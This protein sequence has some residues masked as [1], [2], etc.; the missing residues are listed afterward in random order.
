MY[1]LL[2]SSV[3]KAAYFVALY[4]FP[5]QCLVKRKNAYHTVWI[6]DIEKYDIMEILHL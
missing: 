1:H 6:G 2:F 5:E 3:K 4:V